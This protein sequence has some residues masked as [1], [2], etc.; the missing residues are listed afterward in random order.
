MMGTIEMRCDSL[1]ENGR[2]YIIYNELSITICSEMD[3]VCE[4]LA[5]GGTLY[6]YADNEELSHSLL[7]ECFHFLTSKN[8]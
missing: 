1:F 5:H 4:E 2:Y 8:L 3:D 7:M 6:G